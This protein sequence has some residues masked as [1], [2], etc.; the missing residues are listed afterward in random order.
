YGLKAATLSTAG[1]IATP[2]A[3]AYDLAAIAV[4]VAFLASD[5]IRCGLLRGEQT[6]IIALFVASLAVIP[7]TG[8]APVGAVILVTLLCLILRRIL[9]LRRDGSVAAK[10]A[11]ALPKNRPRLGASY[12]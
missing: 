5:Q 7:T 11:A 10:S 8:K 4:P 9:F 2:Y 1:L 12:T 6:T 3:L